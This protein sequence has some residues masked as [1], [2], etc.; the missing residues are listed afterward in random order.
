MSTTKPRLTSDAP[1]LADAEGGGID[2]GRIFR[3][4]MRALAVLAIVR[5][6]GQWASICGVQ[7]ADGIGFEEMSL[8]LQAMTV[9]FAVIDLVAGVGLWLAAAWGGVV[10]IL[11]AIVALAI[12]ASALMAVEGWVQLAARPLAA[13][14]GDIALIAF[15]VVAA[16]MAA[17]QADA[18]PAD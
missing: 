5:G 17:R 6:L 15:Y 11:A 9:F 8:A 16:T 18:G 4:F 10:W 12:D 7:N 1:I 3:L 14:I 13:T 2:W